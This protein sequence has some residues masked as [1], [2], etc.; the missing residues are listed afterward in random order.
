MDCASRWT[1]GSSASRWNGVRAMP[2]RPQVGKSAARRTLMPPC[3]PCRPTAWPTSA[4]TPPCARHAACRPWWLSRTRRATATRWCG[5]SR[6]TSPA[7]TPPS[8][9]RAS[10]RA[11]SAWATPCCPRPTSR[12]RAPLPARSW[13]LACPTSSTSSRQVTAGRWCPSTSSTAPTAATTAW[14]WPPSRPRLAACTSWWRWTMCPRWAGRWTACAS[15]R[16][17]RRPRWASTPTTA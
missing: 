15:T 3:R 1:S 2:T 5:A 13:A 17:C 6:A 11:T 8:A 16:C 14:R 4:A 10:S 12:P 7:S 9:C